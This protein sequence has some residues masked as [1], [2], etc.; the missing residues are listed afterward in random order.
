MTAIIVLAIYDVLFAILE[1]RVWTTE[2]IGN[3]VWNS[4]NSLHGFAIFC[5]IIEFVLKV[6]K[7]INADCFIVLCCSRK[8]IIAKIDCMI[9]LIDKKISYISFIF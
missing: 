2:E 8:E 6:N 5:S 3:N 7:K 9:I 1:M 4:L